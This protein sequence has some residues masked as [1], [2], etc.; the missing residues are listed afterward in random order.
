[1]NALGSS[2]L[3]QVVEAMVRASLLVAL[4]LLPALGLGAVLLRHRPG[5]RFILL[6]TALLLAAPA[7]LYLAAAKG[8]GADRTESWLLQPRGLVRGL[9]DPIEPAAAPPV[10]AQ[11]ASTSPLRR[12]PPVLPGALLMVWLGGMV[13]AL[14]RLGHGLWRVRGLRRRAVPW[15]PPAGEPPFPVLLS[16]EIAGA[17]VVGLRRPAILVGQALAGGPVAAVE[18]VLVHEAAHARRRDPLWGLCERL[19]QAV[20]WFHPVVLLCRRELARAREEACDDP[21]LARF[22]PAEYART[23]L[24]L[25][26][27]PGPRT[28]AA[29][30]AGAHTAVARRIRRL[31]LGPVRAAPPARARLLLGLATLLGVGGWAL[32][33]LA[34]AAAGPGP[35]RRCWVSA[36]SLAPSAESPAPEFEPA[37]PRAQGAFVLTELGGP[38][39]V[40]NPPL[41]NLRLTPASTFKLLDRSGRARGGCHSRRPHPAALE[42]PAPGND[43]LE[44]GSRSGLGHA[45]LR[46]LVFPGRPRPPGPRPG[47]SGCC[48]DCT[49]ATRTCAVPGG[50]SGST[51]RCAS[52]PWNRR[53]P[54]R[55][56]WRANR[57]PAI[58][59]WTC[60]TRSPSSAAIKMPCC[61]AR[62]E[63]RSPMVAPW[64]G[65]WGTFSG[66][67]AASPTPR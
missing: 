42:R 43:R 55:G 15:S 54:W 63:R 17:A 12:T 58:A 11:P 40:I 4:V 57:E 62:P 41:A 60:S 32:V 49:M 2:L 5:A 6:L 38:T 48:S 65:W 22:A 13:V 66:A 64:P 25:A 20:Y 47:C 45:D 35:A 52:R 3:A 21:V 50:A 8:A 31:L 34:P 46:D 10:A 19:V 27:A 33:V 26:A 29:G 16:P 56:C 18:Q 9:F 61:T 39:V 28:P 37:G 67:R 30:S 1:M 44:P 14:V 59:A 7:P 23:L 53:G 24:A 51:V 36:E